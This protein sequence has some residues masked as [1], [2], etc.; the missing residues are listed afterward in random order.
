MKPEAIAV[1]LQHEAAA[2]PETGLP[3]CYS[4]TTDRMC[5][6]CEQQEQTRDAVDALP[7]IYLGVKA[8]K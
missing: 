7:E 8:A 1:V 2:D 4:R 6:L 3:S 5:V